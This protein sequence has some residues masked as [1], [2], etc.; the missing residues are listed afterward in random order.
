MASWQTP[1]TRHGPLAI[2]PFP[3]QWGGGFCRIPCTFPECP[4]LG[5]AGS[6]WH[7]L[8]TAVPYLWAS[9]VPCAPPPSCLGPALGPGEACES[10]G[11]GCGPQ[12][13][14]RGHPEMCSPGAGGMGARGPRL[15]V[16]CSPH[17]RLCGD[18]S[19]RRPSLCS[20][21]ASWGPGVPGFWR[22]ALAQAPLRRGLGSVTLYQGGG[23]RALHAQEAAAWKRKR[24]R[25]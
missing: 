16:A 1:V 12:P 24:P 9:C 18:L 19:P 5:G 22:S 15:L 4:H 25:A 17:S 21:L 10:R 23:G 11:V 2:L 8:L 14:H 13:P 7:E 6:A 3:G 20:I